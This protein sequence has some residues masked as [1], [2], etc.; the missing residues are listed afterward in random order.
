MTDDASRGNGSSGLGHWSLIGHWDLGLGHSFLLALFF[1]LD[2]LLGAALG[3]H[4]AAHVAAG[5]GL[6]SLRFGLLGG[7]GDG[8][9]RGAAYDLADVAFDALARGGEFCLGVGARGRGATR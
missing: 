2:R 3:F 9:I 4:Q 6:H 8:F 7:G 5:A 1:L